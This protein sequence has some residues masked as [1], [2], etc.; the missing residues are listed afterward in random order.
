MAEIQNPNQQGGGG[1]QDSRSL[2]GLLIVFVLMMIAFEYF[3][4]K[5]PTTPPQHPQEKSQPAQNSAPA[6]PEAESTPAE[7]PA[8]TG[9]TH[10]THGASAKPSAPNTVE[11]ASEKDI[12]VE[13]EFYRITFTNRGGA[14]KSWILKKYKSDDQKTPLDL[15]NHEA[16]SQFGLPLSLFTY[17]AALKNKLNSALY[18]PSSSAALT[19]P[20]TLS[21]EYS[22]GGLTVHKT[23]RFDSSYVIHADVTVTQNGAP[24]TALLQWPSGMGDQ[25]DL[26][27]YAASVF[28][29]SDNGKTDSSPRR[30]S[31][32]A[33]RCTAPSITRASATC[34]SPPSLCRMCPPIPAS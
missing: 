30:R 18:V 4:P 34:I 10:K 13:N 2:F 17:D 11:A 3:S 16:A 26:A 9:A 24:V 1:G 5:K 33:I 7:A 6:A 12:V 22:A 25:T 27:G 32:A 8:Q 21:F 15:V 14:V 31:W 29:Q 23:Y 19:A 20:G 28:D